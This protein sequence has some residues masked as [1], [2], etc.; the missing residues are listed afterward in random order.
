MKPMPFSLRM[1]C[2]PFQLIDY[3]V[4]GILR[5]IR[6]DYPHPLNLGTDF[7]ISINEL[8]KLAMTIEKKIYQLN[9]SLDLWG[10]GVEAATIL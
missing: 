8:A 4:E 9:I 5:I 3:C 10:L 2:P 1:V 7:S 6:S